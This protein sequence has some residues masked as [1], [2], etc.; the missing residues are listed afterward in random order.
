MQANL[1]TVARLDYFWKIRQEQELPSP[2]S[3][4]TS[5]VQSDLVLP[6]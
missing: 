2:P 3:A 1:A 6:S 4:E 5:S